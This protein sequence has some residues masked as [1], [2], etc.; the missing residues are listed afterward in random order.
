MGINI[1]LIALVFWAA[2]CLAVA[3][4]LDKWQEHRYDSRSTPVLMQHY[5]RRTNRAHPRRW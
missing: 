2:G 5:S 1:V 4:L 3:W